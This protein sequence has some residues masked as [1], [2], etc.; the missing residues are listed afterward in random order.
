MPIDSKTRGSI[1]ESVVVTWLEQHG[2]RIIER[3]FRQRY[4]EID[5]IVQRNEHLVFVEVKSRKHSLDLIADL[6][7]Y[8][9]QQK[10][11]KVAQAFL[12]HGLWDNK[13]IRFDIAIVHGDEYDVQ[14]LS[15]AFVPESNYF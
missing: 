15:N 1:G 2:Y 7:P 14:Y 12:A 5:I 11:I 4:G 8:K 9:K 13:I 10:I 6:V 3:N